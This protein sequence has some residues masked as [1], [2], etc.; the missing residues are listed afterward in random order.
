[1]KEAPLRAQFK[2]FFRHRAFRRIN[3]AGHAPDWADEFYPLQVWSLRWSIIS[4]FHSLRRF[5]RRPN[6]TPGR[7]HLLKC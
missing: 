2:T 5:S 3:P 4:L 1:V 6:G 7:T